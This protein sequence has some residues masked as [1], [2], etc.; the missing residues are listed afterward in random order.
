[1]VSFC[2]HQGNNSVIAIF[3]TPLFP[4]VKFEPMYDK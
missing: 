4:Q 1:M 3:S 2:S